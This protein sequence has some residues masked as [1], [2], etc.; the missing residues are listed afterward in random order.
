MKKNT[1]FQNEIISFRAFEGKRVKK[2]LTNKFWYF[3]KYFQYATVQYQIFFEQKKYFYFC[4]NFFKYMYYFNWL[5]FFSLKYY[6]IYLE[7]LRMFNLKLP[8]VLK[9]KMYHPGLLQKYFFLK[10]KLPKIFLT[11]TPFLKKALVFNQFFLIFYFFKF[12]IS[13]YKLFQVLLIAKLRLI[14]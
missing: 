1:I 9:K 6:P 12:C 8:V 5:K 2:R 4:Y 3:K 11:H 7:D 10:K 14:S 13:F